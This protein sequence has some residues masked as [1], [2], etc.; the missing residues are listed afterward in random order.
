MSPRPVQ[1][2]RRRSRSEHRLRYRQEANAPYR[3][4]SDVAPRWGLA[5][6]LLLAISSPAPTPHSAIA[7]LVEQVTVNHRVA[8]SSPARGASALPI[9]SMVSGFGLKDSRESVSLCDRLRR[10]ARSHVRLDRLS[11]VRGGKRT[12]GGD[13]DRFGTVLE[14]LRCVDRGSRP[15]SP[16]NDLLSQDVLTDPAALPVQPGQPRSLCSVASSA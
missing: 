5:S 4:K 15:D 8:G 14:C 16:E 7:Q 6:R 1:A 3:S 10:V 2:S 12:S 9:K 11:S 13:I